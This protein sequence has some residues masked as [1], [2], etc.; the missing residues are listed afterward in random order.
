M[1]LFTNGN[2]LI[3]PPVSLFHLNYKALTVHFGCLKP[4]S[5]SLAHPPS[6]GISDLRTFSSEYLA[7]KYQLI[8]LQ[9]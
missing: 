4:G 5:Q 8:Q 9:W 7:D 2:K 6:D 1:A 3:H